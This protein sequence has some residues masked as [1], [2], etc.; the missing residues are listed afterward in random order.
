MASPLLGRWNEVGEPRVQRT[1]LRGRLACGDRGSEQRMRE[2]ESLAVELEDAGDE[3][4][5]EARAAPGT[6]SSRVG[7]WFGDGGDDPGDVERG[8]AETG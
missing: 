4:L 8:R 2:S 7:G 6:A 3:R 5:G 1:P